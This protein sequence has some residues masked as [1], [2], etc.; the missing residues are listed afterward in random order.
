M[1]TTI[2]IGRNPASDLVVGNA[3]EIVSNNHADLTLEDDG[4]LRYTDHSSN[5]TVINGREI[6]NESVFVTTD[7]DVRLADSFPIDWSVVYDLLPDLRRIDSKRTRRINPSAYNTPAEDNTEAATAP[8][9]SRG[10]E[11]FDHSGI[12]PTEPMNGGAAESHA[13][14]RFEGGAYPSLNVSQ[15]EPAGNTAKRGSNETVR[16]RSSGKNALSRSMSWTTIILCF[17]AF[18]AVMAILAFTVF[19]DVVLDIM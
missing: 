11:R 6:H 13:T 3:F 9:N 5:G 7:D 8:R 10:T 17:V 12:F 2:T 19:D 16:R 15:A 14:E 18:L 1:S 4:R